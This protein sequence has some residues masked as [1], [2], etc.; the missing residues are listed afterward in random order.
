MPT[1]RLAFSPPALRFL[2]FVA[3]GVL[4]TGFGYGLFAVIVAFGVPLEIS[5]LLSTTLGI[6]FNFITT[7]SLVFFKRTPKLFVPF[8][9]VYIVIYFLNVV[10]LRLVVSC[11][12]VPAIGQALLMPIIVVM[13]YFGMSRYVFG[14]KKS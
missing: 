9:L 10:L 4:N 3:V 5:L 11:G 6:V 13:S 1:L 14:E 8:A 2:R 7:G 12:L